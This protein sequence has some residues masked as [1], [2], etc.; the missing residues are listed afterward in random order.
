MDNNNIKSLE[1]KWFKYKTKRYILIFVLSVMSIIGIFV[2]ISKYINQQDEVSVQQPNPNNVETKKELNTNVSSTIQQIIDSRANIQN[3]PAPTQKPITTP[4]PTLAPTPTPTV[5]SETLQ[6]PVPTTIVMQPINTPIPSVEPTLQEPDKS[7][8]KLVKSDDDI[9]KVLKKRYTDSPTSTLA[10]SL[11][12]EF[13]KRGNY[14]ESLGWSI[15][16]NEL[17]DVLEDAWILYAENSVKLG[18]KDDAVIA[19]KTYLNK[20]ESSKIKAFLNK[21]ENA[22]VTVDNN[23]STSSNVSEANKDNLDAESTKN[24]IALLKKSYYTSPNIKDATELYNS[25]M[26]IKSYE[27]A[28]FWAKKVV[29]MDSSLEDGYIYMANAAKK[30]GDKKEAISLIKEFLAKK[31]SKKLEQLLN[32]IKD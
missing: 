14:Q 31:E 32:E 28:V 13:Y 11:A 15:R 23:D 22:E 1:K 9:I 18:K 4:T 27:Y 17:D 3:T 25:Y 21:I 29:K 26:S 16:A 20:Y 8:I 2:L 19:L 12:S 10:L 7:S 5:V 24:T 30:G 6:I